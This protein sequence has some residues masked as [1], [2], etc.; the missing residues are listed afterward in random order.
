MTTTPVTW[1]G[2]ID[3]NDGSNETG[4]QIAPRITELR[5]GRI[6]VSW[7]D[8]G[9]NYDNRVN[10][11]FIGQ[12]YEMDGTP[13]GNPFL[14]NTIFHGGTSYPNSNDERGHDVVAMPDGGWMIVYQDDN[15]S[16]TFIRA[17]RFDA[18]GILTGN[19]TLASGTNT[20]GDN[21]SDPSIATNS[22][23]DWVVTFSRQDG[24]GTDTEGFVFDNNTFLPLDDFGSRSEEGWST[25]G[26][27]APND[28]AYLS[29][30]NI[31]TVNEDYAGFSSHTRINVRVNEPD[32]TTISSSLTETGSIAT[33]VFRMDFPRV[34]EIPT[35][36]FVVTYI[37]SSGNT[38]GVRAAVYANDGSTVVNRF[39][40]ESGSL[41]SGNPFRFS[42]V[43][44]LKDGGFI[45]AWEESNQLHIQRFDGSG[46]TIGAERIFTGINPGN[47]ATSS[48]EAF[49]MRLMQDG[50]VAITWV[51]D[52][53]SGLNIGDQV[54]FMI[55]DPRNDGI[56]INGTSGIDGLTTPV[57][58]ATVNAGAGADNVLGHNG[59]DTF[60]DND[61]TSGDHYDGRGGIDT[62]DYSSVTFAGS[63]TI[64]LVN[65][66]VINSFSSLFD[67]IE[68][69]ENVV[70]SQGND[71]IV[72]VF[73]TT[74]VDA[75]GGNDRV[76]VNDAVANGDVYNGGSGTDTFDIS[77]L[78][79]LVASQVHLGISQWTLLGGTETINN[80]ENVWGANNVNVTETIIGTIGANELRGNGGD[81]IIIGGGGLD[82]MFGGDDDDRFEMAIGDIV[83]GETVN[84]GADFD[85]I[86]L[87][88]SAGAF[89]I[90]YITTL[91]SIEELE[92]GSSLSS[93]FNTLYFN[94]NQFS[95]GFAADAQFLGTGNS[96]R[97]FVTM[98]AAT[99]LD[100]SQLVFTN[101]G[102]TLNDEDVV[103]TG[104]ASHETITGTRLD[105]E[106]LG[107]DGNDIIDG[108]TGDDFLDGQGGTNTVSYASAI[109]A[110]TVTLANQTNFQNTIGA[111]IDSLRN[112]SHL[113]GSD[114]SDTLSGN[115]G[116]NIIRGGKGE[117][118]IDGGGNY[119]SGTEQLLGED[120][121]DTIMRRH[122][123][124]ADTT[125]YDGGN[126]TDTLVGFD[127]LNNA[128]VDFENG[129]IRINGLRQDFILNFENYE[130]ANAEGFIGNSQNNI[131]TFTGNFVNVIDGRNG[132]DEIHAG[133]GNDVITGGLGRDDMYGD[134]G[135]DRFI[136][137]ELDLAPLELINGGAN[138]DTVELHD[139]GNFD[140]RDTIF[141]SVEILT[142]ASGSFNASATMW[143]SQIGAG[144]A[145][146]IGNSG[147]AD[148]LQFWLG[149]EV[150][151]DLSGL[152]FQTWQGGDLV[153]IYGTT[154][155]DEITGSMVADNIRGDIGQDI[156]LGGDGDDTIEGGAD[157]DELHGDGNTSIGDTLS[158][159]GSNSGVTVFLATNT[160]SGGHADG[161]TVSGFENV[162]GSHHVDYIYGDAGAN[163]INGNNGAD[164]LYGGANDDTLNGGNGADLMFGEAG[165]DIMNGGNDGDYMW[166]GTEGDTMHG[167]S[168]IDWLRGEEG[169]DF[170]YG[171]SGDDVLIGGSGDDQMWGGTD[172]DTF[173][174]EDDNDWIYGEANGDVAFG[175]LGDDHI[176]G[177]SEGD[178][179][180][181]GAGADVIN[182]GT[183]NDLMWGDMPGTYDSAADT[184]EFDANWGFDAVYDFELGKDLVH[185]TGIAG[186]T[187]FSDLTLIDGGANVTVVFGGD[188]ITFYGVTESQ[189]VNNQGD[190]SFI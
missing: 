1:L 160:V 95:G 34:S 148:L 75:Q 183:E 169:E 31:V 23:G 103:I 38:S 70:G 188:A 149:T 87:Y 101:W 82:Q 56:T 83:S 187:Q 128:V 119:T 112:F 140:L 130:G 189:L 62:I 157:A 104:D 72:T 158:Y 137:R 37:Y 153:F 121:N 120:G 118:T 54:Q 46:G 21:V 49:D 172:T 100:M 74:N 162:T 7:R 85:T 181:G 11:D 79:Q 81:D 15:N 132:D 116:A 69:I 13:I 66:T 106:I 33:A 115:T 147:G 65:G 14:M 108:A 89:H 58:G 167:N 146:V 163:T 110:V 127:L 55:L 180:F 68:N 174:G 177:G 156:I 77:G 166:G 107:G 150:K 190:F 41:A 59:N 50:R 98:G 88:G 36:G 114:H 123:S 73:D 28:T 29:N 42:D 3:V 135:N 71:T 125:T 155:G 170:L 175:Q 76:V 9:D 131:A 94:A 165:A 27:P 133:S 97:I 44:G 134:A 40:V 136:L 171:D 154:A 109:A 80:F 92:L 10:G 30:G 122:S 143:A 184:F 84:G 117:D 78:T 48:F 93:G 90:D 168:G 19:Y 61:F 26:L 186:L 126:D 51:E 138:T 86:A 185:F 4:D 91:V 145:G 141:S 161:D 142:F 144:F 173:Y 159:A 18:T 67:Y 24:N 2:A 57:G 63:T 43:V 176:Y 25:A 179:L 60:I 6:L 124:T 152:T 22:S 182:G 8:D 45:V 32:G 129:E 113:T 53:Q 17:E 39:F 20:N 52:S 35:G 5:D 111:G 96:E 102:Y 105:D 16:A 47:S 178:F 64:D 151:I 139:G 12:L 99:H 164:W